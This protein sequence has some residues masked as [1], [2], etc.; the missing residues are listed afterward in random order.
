MPVSLV[1]RAEKALWTLPASELPAD[2]PT[3]VDRRGLFQLRPHHDY[4]RVGIGDEYVSVRRTSFLVS[5]ADTITVYAAQGSTFDAVIADMQ[6]PPNLSPEK[7]WLACYVMLSRARHL[8]GQ[9][10]HARAHRIGPLRALLD[11]QPHGFLRGASKIRSDGF[12]DSLS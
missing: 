9:N 1:L 3:G 7:H 12:C 2:L 11:F 6:R 8:P 4:L 10:P 5:P